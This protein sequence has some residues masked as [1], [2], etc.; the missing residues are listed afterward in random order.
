MQTGQRE[1]IYWC[2]RQKTCSR[3]YSM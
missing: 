3:V 2:D 1:L